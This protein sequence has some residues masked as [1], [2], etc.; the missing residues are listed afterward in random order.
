M[1]A[2]GLW[3]RPAVMDGTATATM[4][5]CASAGALA[6]IHDR[7][8]VHADPGAALDWILDERPPLDL[9]DPSVLPAV[10]PR[11]ASSRV[12]SIRNNGP[13]LLEPDDGVEAVRPDS[14]DRDAEPPTLF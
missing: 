8:P 11:R 9:A 6:L 2:L 14:Q 7:S 13:S 4:L 5:T 12:N 1:F 10:R 3:N